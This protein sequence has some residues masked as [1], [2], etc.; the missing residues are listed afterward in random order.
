MSDLV[1]TIGNAADSA[2]A[3]DGSSSETAATATFK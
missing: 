3:A 1:P 2:A